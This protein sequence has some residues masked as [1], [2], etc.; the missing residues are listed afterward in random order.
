MAH[1]PL[2]LRLDECA[3]GVCLCERCECECVLIAKV[4][5]DTFAKCI[6]A[7]ENLKD[8]GDYTIRYILGQVEGTLYDLR[9]QP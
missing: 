7:V 4:R 2:C 1:D 8:G 5:E 9:D 6:E 3:T